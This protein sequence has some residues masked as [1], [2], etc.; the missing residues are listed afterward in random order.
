MNLLNGLRDSIFSYT[1][2]SIIAD[3]SV[4]VADKSV[5]VAESVTAGALS[6]T[7]CA[8]PGS[9]RFY[10]GGICA[11]GPHAKIKLFDLPTNFEMSNH[12]TEATAMVMARKVSQIFSSHIGLA[13]VGYSLPY[14]RDGTDTECELYVSVPYSICVLYDRALDK[15]VSRKMEFPLIS[16]SHEC[17]LKGHRSHVQI[18]TA[19][20]CCEMYRLY[21]K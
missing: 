11:Y 10:R 16:Y 7:L 2:Q 12:A 18:A 13:T 3:K 17:Q 8:E 14:E 21:T 9:I 15:F 1:T 20:A 6:I 5:A 19:E 4:A